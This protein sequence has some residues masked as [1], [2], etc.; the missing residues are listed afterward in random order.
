MKNGTR[1]NHAYK[2]ETDNKGGQ[3]NKFLIKLQLHMSF[4]VILKFHSMESYSQAIKTFPPKIFLPQFLQH[5]LALY[6]T[7]TEE[8]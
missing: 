1:L 3:G 2:R 5:L 8:C 6:S 4:S 7:G